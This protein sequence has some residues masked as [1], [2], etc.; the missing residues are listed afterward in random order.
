MHRV[1]VLAMEGFVIF[2]LAIAVDMFSRAKS[3]TG[4]DLYET[5]VCGNSKSVKG[6]LF[7]LHLR[8]NLSILQ[9]SDTIIIPGVSDIQKPSEPT[10]LDAL[11]KASDKGTR[12]ASICSGAFVLAEAGLLDGLR[13]TT[14]WRGAEE[15]AARYPR[16][17]VEAD[18]LFIDNG[19]ILTSA[20]VASG[21]DL[22]LHIIRRDH[23]AVAAADVADNIVMPLERT[24]IHS[25]RIKR[26]VTGSSAMHDILLW[27][28]EN[29]NQDLGLEQIAEHFNLTS[30]TI[31]RW[32]RE[33]TGITALQWILAAKI[34]RSQQ[35]LETTDLSVEDVAAGAGFSSSSAF[36]DRFHRITG[37][38]P[39]A[40]RKTYRALHN[41]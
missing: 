27:I 41:K 34:R 20:G 15:L 22:C 13:A 16:V 28:T 7:D 24:G 14:H 12:I 3:R 18:V 2:D 6:H 26:D 38:S 23:G 25:Q 31:G 29:L 8:D 33:H 17:Q 10:L 5:Y 4:M 40:W 36:R 11:R 30:R 35:L 32:F 37:A 39:S 1:T 9:Q 21:I 19:K